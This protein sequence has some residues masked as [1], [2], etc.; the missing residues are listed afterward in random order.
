M[1][2]TKSNTVSKPSGTKR[3]RAHV[4]STQKSKCKQDKTLNKHATSTVAVQTKYYSERRCRKCETTCIAGTECIATAPLHLHCSPPYYIYNA[5]RKPTDPQTRREST[6]IETIALHT[7]S[8]SI[9]LP[10]LSTGQAQYL[11]E[12]TS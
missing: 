3:T 7:A 1:I 10:H 2:P 6:T 8:E 4:K 11:Y 5:I 9:A 12:H